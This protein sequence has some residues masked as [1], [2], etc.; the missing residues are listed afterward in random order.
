MGKRYVQFISK[1]TKYFTRNKA[2]LKSHL[3][4]P[5]VRGRCVLSRSGFN[6]LPVTAAFR[7]AVFHVTK[8]IVADFSDSDRNLNGVSARQVQTS[9]YDD[10]VISLI[11]NHQL[12][13]VK[14]ISVVVFEN[15]R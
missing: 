6:Y 3:R 10:W 14:T 11:V 1:W 4:S 13:A 2:V 15:L 5:G 9:V 12:K 8:N 7:E